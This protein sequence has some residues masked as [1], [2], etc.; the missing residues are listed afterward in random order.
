MNELGR[1]QFVCTLLEPLQASRMIESPVHAARY[2]RLIPYEKDV[3]LGGD[4]TETWN[5]L[6]S[7]L[8]KKR[9]DVEDHATLLCSLLLGFGLD[10]YCCIGTVSFYPSLSLFMKA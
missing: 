10:A 6:F 3:S 7:F 2:V 1:R 5:S 9:G 8:C 4:R